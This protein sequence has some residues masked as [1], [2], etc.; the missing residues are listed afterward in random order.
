MTGP[1]HPELLDWLTTEF[2]SQ[3]WDQKAM[4]RLIVTSNTYRQASTVTREILD[5]DPA[6]MLFTRGPRFRVEAPSA[7]TT[8][9]AYG[10]LLSTSSKRRRWLSG[11]ALGTRRLCERAVRLKDSQT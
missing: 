10:R 9:A 5:R 6:N 11:I 4:Q 8:V 2:V 1:S 3:G 7:R